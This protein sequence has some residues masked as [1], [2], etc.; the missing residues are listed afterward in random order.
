[1]M[2]EVRKRKAY[3]EIPDGDIAEEIDFGTVA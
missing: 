2:A 1:M 3:N